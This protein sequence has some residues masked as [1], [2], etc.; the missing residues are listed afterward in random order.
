MQTL[1]QIREML[2]SR[3]LAPQK[4]LGQNFLI[5]H[6]LIRKLVEASGVQRGDLVLEVG[7]GTGAL[8]EEL[9]ARGCEVVACEKDRG[10]A[11]LLR[12]RLKDPG[13]AD[14]VGLGTTSAPSASQR[15]LR[16]AEVGGTLTL[17]EGD[18]LAS[19]R[20]LNP[21]IVAALGAG[22]SEWSPISPTGSP[23]P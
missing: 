5:D 9:I 6:N 7:P 11:A 15:R 13:A 16:R 8:T 21:E 1:A 2:E 18:C 23:R 14:V 19:K 10:L 22:P 20:A 17:I 4:S 3:G 12:E